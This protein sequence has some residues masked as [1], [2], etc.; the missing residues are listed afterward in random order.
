VIPV[1]FNTSLLMQ[2]GSCGRFNGDDW[3]RL[4]SPLAA[5]CRVNPLVPNVA[6]LRSLL[7]F[8]N[9]CTLKP[10][11]GFDMPEWRTCCKA[12]RHRVFGTR[13]VYQARFDKLARPIFRKLAVK[14]TCFD[15]FMDNVIESTKEI[16]LV[17]KQS[18]DSFLSVKC[19]RSD[20]HTDMSCSR[21]DL[22]ALSRF[23]TPLI[24]YL[25]MLLS[26]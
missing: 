8:D 7:I 17:V 6:R 21:N 11:R 19:K 23:D 20:L 12:H 9:R 5:I 3:T 24:I 10:V 2:R 25:I 13:R 18:V 15:H 26:F 22:D 4:G 14:N 1:L 16:S